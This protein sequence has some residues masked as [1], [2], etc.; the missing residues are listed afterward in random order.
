MLVSADESVK[1]KRG[2]GKGAASKVSAR[3]NGTQPAASV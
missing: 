1:L 3:K 2:K